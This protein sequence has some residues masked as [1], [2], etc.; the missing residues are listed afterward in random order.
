MDKKEMDDEAKIFTDITDI[1]NGI[2]DMK[3]DDNTNNTILY[4]ES[5]V[6]PRLPNNPWTR[7][8]LGTYS[9]RCR[10]ENEPYYVRDLRCIASLSNAISQK[11]IVCVLYQFANSCQIC[12][13]MYINRKL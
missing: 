12:K 1:L 11:H 6:P 7:R 2:T 4:G 9:F 10:V 3:T 13:H 5:Y 8:Q